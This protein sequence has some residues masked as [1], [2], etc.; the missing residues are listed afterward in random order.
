[1]RFG[2]AGD[3]VQAQPAA[4]NL[5]RHCPAPAVERLEDVLAILG[6]DAEAAIR[7]RDRHMRAAGLVLRSDTV[8]AV[9]TAVPDLPGGPRTQRASPPYFTPLLIRFWTAERRAPTSPCTGGSSSGS[10]QLQRHAACLD[11]RPA[12]GDRLLDDLGDAH[13]RLRTCRAAGRDSSQLQHPLHGFREPPRLALDCLAV[14]LAPARDRRPRH[15]RGCW[16]P[17]RSPTPA[18]AARVT[19][20]RRTPSAAAPASAR[21]GPTPRSSRWRWSAGAG[22]PS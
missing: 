7:H 22:C 4:L 12:C 19:P 9:G 6:R 11:L 18:S 17:C 21:A 15:Q 8:N 16:P 1:M 5:P 14:L 2:D 20:P 10:A 13:R 3:E